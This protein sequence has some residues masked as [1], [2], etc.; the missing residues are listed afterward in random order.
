[1]VSAQKIHGTQRQMIEKRSMMENDIESASES[2]EDDGFQI[3]ISGGKSGETI[4]LSYIQSIPK[5]EDGTRSSHGSQGHP[6][7]CTPCCFFIR[8]RGC[9]DGMLCSMC[10]D[11]HPTDGYSRR[12][13]R[14][15]KK[16]AKVVECNKRL[17]PG[18]LVQSN[19]VGASQ[20]EAIMVYI[21]N[22][23]F[24]ACI[25]PVSRSRTS[26]RSQSSP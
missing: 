17:N 25:S 5:K 12:K 4:S 24:E 10:H 16:A 21:K 22:T 14:R 18:E 11:S 9:A 2:E 23:F 20:S 15:L 1:M 26:V 7:Q 8:A 13:K 3:R 19:G 6:D